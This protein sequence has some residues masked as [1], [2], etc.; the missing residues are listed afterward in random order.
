MTAISMLAGESQWRSRR[1]RYYSGDWPAIKAILPQFELVPFKAGP[2]EPA[3][4]FF[5]TVM[6]RPLSAVERPMPLGIVSNTY[7]L[8]PHL[9]VAALCQKGLLDAGMTPNELRYE[10]GLSELGEWMN[11]RI[12]FP[13]SY[14]FTDASEEKLDLRLECFNSV[15]GSSRLVI[16][17]GWLRFVCSNGLVIG[18]T[19]I[20]IKERHGQ[21]LNLVAIPER[22]RVALEAVGA[23]RSRMKSWEAEKYP[24]MTSRPGQ[25]QALLRSGENERRRESTTFVT[26]ERTSRSRIPSPLARRQKRQSGI[27]APSPAPPN[28]P[29][30]NMRFHKPYPSLRHIEGMQKTGSRDKPTS[31]FC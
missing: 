17:F 20:E 25:I 27:W 4:P 15:D 19:K 16:F 1:V 2:N 3:N 14:S 26:P 13:D 10:V 31:P 18:E 23:D 28:G 8:A 9:D 29:R 22:I 11:F 5:Q 7:S 30:Q 6:R 24:L 21:S 12:Y